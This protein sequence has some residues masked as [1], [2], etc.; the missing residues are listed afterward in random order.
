MGARRKDPYRVKEGFRVY[1][2]AA[3]LGIMRP[4]LTLHSMQPSCVFGVPCLLCLSIRDIQAEGQRHTSRYVPG[5]SKSSLSGDAG[6][7]EAL[8]VSL[9][10]ALFWGGFAPVTNVSQIVS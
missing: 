6:A 8:S 1:G 7:Q 4:E 9:G 3:W 2:F 10:Q 5:V